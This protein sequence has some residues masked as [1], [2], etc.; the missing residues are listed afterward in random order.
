MKKLLKNKLFFTL[1]MLFTSEV[2]ADTFGFIQSIKNQNAFL[3]SPDQSASILK[4][5][6]FL[7]A[8]SEMLIEE[9]GLVIFLDY[10]DH[11]YQLGSG[12]LVKFKSEGIELS[13]GYLRVKTLGPSAKIIKIE[14][15]N[16]I[17]SFSN[18]E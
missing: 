5:G 18:S 1:L 17:V 15:P 11:K 2:F 6:D 4:D 8:N 13:R 9:G 16:S 10:F 7:E 12:G 14:T 3:V